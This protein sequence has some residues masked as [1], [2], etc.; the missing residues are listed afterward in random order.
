MGADDYSIDG[1][2]KE[3]TDGEAIAHLVKVT[4]QKPMSNLD[5]INLLIQLIDKTD[6]SRIIERWAHETLN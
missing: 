4:G 2:V 1:V 5:A 6:K 3:L